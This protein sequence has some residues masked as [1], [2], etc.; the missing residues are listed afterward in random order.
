VYQDHAT[1]FSEITKVA[2]KA[3]YYDLL[4]G[5]YSLYPSVILAACLA[6]ALAVVLS[7][8][9][10]IYSDQPL[11]S[12]SDLAKNLNPLGS[13]KTQGT[14]IKTPFKRL[15]FSL[16]IILQTF[17]KINLINVGVARSNAVNILL[18]LNYLVG[19]FFLSAWSWI[20]VNCPFWQRYCN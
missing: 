16:V 14:E 3:I 10:I 5:G 7:R 15:L 1:R 11:F 2:Y 17:L 4:G 19:A 6:I 13:T 8:I 18:Y 9:S 20:L 12:P